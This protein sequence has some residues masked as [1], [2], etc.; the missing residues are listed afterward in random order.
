MTLTK[1]RVPL[2]EYAWFVEPTDPMEKV[3]S[4]NPIVQLEAAR[5][6]GATFIGL[7]VVDDDAALT[8]SSIQ[9]I[10]TEFEDLAQ[11]HPTLVLADRVIVP[12]GAAELISAIEGEDLHAATSSQLAEFEL[13]GLDPARLANTLLGAGLT[14]L[15]LTTPAI[16]SSAPLPAVN[17]VI[18]LSTATGPLTAI[19]ANTL[20]QDRTSRK[21]LHIWTVTALRGSDGEDVRRLIA[22]HA[23]V[24]GL[25]RDGESRMVQGLDHVLDYRQRKHLNEILTGSAPTRINEINTST[26]NALQTRKATATQWMSYTP[27]PEL[28]PELLIEEPQEVPGFK[29]NQ[30]VNF[31]VTV[32]YVILIAVAVRFA[33]LGNLLGTALP[34]L[35]AAINYPII[36]DIGRTVRSSASGGAQFAQLFR[37]LQASASDLGRS[38]DLPFV[39]LLQIH[40]VKWV[41]GESEKIEITI[42]DRE[43]SDCQDILEAAHQVLTPANDESQWVLEAGRAD[44]TIGRSLVWLVTLL[45]HASKPRYF[46]LPT[47][48]TSEEAARAFATHWCQFVGPCRLTQSTEEAAELPGASAR[49]AR[50][51][52]LA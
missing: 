13:E 36:T 41:K 31:T 19:R 21:T 8:A 1:S 33:L 17:T 26:L 39:H 11:F 28:T 46:A 49:A 12:A 2:R 14:Q 44:F 40:P 37:V 16:A 30:S 24:W 48:I 34:L 23:Q 32:L 18:D 29:L 22:K 45:F 20:A 38:F 5:M 25:S 42:K 7:A 35:I 6:D 10:V 51:R 52:D 9:C 3:R 4:L 43:M 27:L 50:I 15:L 47:Q